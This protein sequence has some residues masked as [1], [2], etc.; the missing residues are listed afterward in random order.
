MKEI[1]LNIATVLYPLKKH[2]SELYK[3]KLYAELTIQDINFDQIM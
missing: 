1:V 3:R 2:S